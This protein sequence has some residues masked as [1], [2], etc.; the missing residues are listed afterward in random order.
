VGRTLTT[1]A[2]VSLH[3]APQVPVRDAAAVADR[4]ARGESFDSLTRRQAG[5]LQRDTRAATQVPSP[6]L[7]GVIAELG[8]CQRQLCFWFVEE[9]LDEGDHPLG[10]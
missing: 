4:A 10:F 8:A 6:R 7:A 5:P 3:R 1:I 2:A 9:V